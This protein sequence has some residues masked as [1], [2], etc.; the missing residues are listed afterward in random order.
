MCGSDHYQSALLLIHLATYNRSSSSD[1]KQTNQLKV[2]LMTLTHLITLSHILGGI[3]SSLHY[4]SNT[5]HFF[6]AIFIL[7][8]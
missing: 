3:Y 4:Q 2:P 1:S 8:S 7:C 5:V 6:Y